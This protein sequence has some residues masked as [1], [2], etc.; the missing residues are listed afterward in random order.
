MH[1]PA[2]ADDGI[3]PAI[4]QTLGTTDASGRVD[5]RQ[6]R[7]LKAGRRIRIQAEAL[8]KHLCQGLAGCRIELRAIRETGLTRLNGL[9]CG[10]TPWPAALTAITPRQSSGEGRRRR[11]VGL[12]SEVVG[13]NAE[14]GAQGESQQGHYHDPAYH[15]GDLTPP[16]G[17][18]S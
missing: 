8:H 6:R 13:R 5:G 4:A 3:R 10:L 1:H 17:V 18:D 7:F 9:G 12:D 2:G 15:H 16:V 14:Q 11:I